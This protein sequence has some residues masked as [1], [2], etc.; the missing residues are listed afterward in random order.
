MKDT[1]IFNNWIKNSSCILEKNDSSLEI[2]N[3][4]SNLQG[5]SMIFQFS[6]MIL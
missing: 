1:N 5:S 2:N 4:N 6:A 3:N